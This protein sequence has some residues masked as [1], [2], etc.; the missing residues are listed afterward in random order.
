MGPFE[1]LDYVGLDTTSFI[2]QG[3]QRD[4]PVWMVWYGLNENANMLRNQPV[5]QLIFLATC[6]H[7]HSYTVAAI[8]STRARR[9]FLLDSG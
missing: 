2:S 7:T 1:L 5:I 9:S 8:A 6:P 4:Y 3:W